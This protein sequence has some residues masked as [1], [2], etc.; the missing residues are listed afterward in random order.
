MIA[1]S[2]ITSLDDAIDR[3]ANQ[4]VQ[5]TTLYVFAKP[6]EAKY[7]SQF[8]STD[9]SFVNHVPLSYLSMCPPKNDNILKL[10]EAELTQSTTVG[11]PAPWGHALSRRARYSRAMFEIASPQFVSETVKDEEIKGPGLLEK[12]IAPLKPAGQPEGGAM[13]FFDVAV[14]IGALVY[15]LP[16]VAVTLG[17]VGVATYKAYGM[18]G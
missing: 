14:G 9:V 17:V 11:P 3:L 6:N 13:G 18:F 2:P 4:D 7:L 10:W 15:L 1:L 8:I 16:S 12:A 5:L